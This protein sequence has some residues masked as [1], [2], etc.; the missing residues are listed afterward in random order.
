MPGGLTRP[1]TPRESPARRATDGSVPASGGLL[2]AL[3]HAVLGP[4]PQM[5]VHMWQC[6]IAFGL[7]CVVAIVQH[8]EVLLG[9][10]EAPQSHLLTAYT[11]GTSLLCCGLVRSG[12]ARRMA[13]GDPALTMVQALLAVTALGWS[14]AITGPARGAL[15]ALLAPLFLLGGMF[16]LRA[17]QTRVLMGYWLALVTA[18]MLWR[19]SGDAPRYDPRVEVI[20][21]AFSLIVVTA[22]A[23]LA[24]RISTLLTRLAAQKA[25][26]IEALETSRKLAEHDAL[27]GL[28]NRRGMAGLLTLHWTVGA[29]A[30]APRGVK[31]PASGAP[32]A[33]AM[34]DIDL[35]KNVNDTHGHA[36]GDAVLQ[37]FAQ[38]AQ[39][40]VRGRDVLS[41]W[42]GE[43][44]L[45][46]MPGTGR[47][48]A[49]RVLE[50]LR[51]QIARGEFGALAP[52][53]ELTFSA[54][55]AERQ[56]GEPYDAAV[57]RADKALYRAKHN[58]RNRF[59]A[60]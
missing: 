43:E 56:A 48:G 14:Y 28:L 58:G 22:V 18:V 32:M 9:L 27:T 44:F 47:D 53:L 16:Q 12:L 25:S 40:G 4:G 38:I 31:V 8:A 55:V 23:A 51:G 59:E 60:G 5:Q 30:Q 35:F 13:P 6:L 49:M 46:L 34:M 50:R 37:R 54:G 26:L 1:T 15:L 24:I 10:I 33:I 2:G 42:G 52:G 39:A 29:T 7:L 11:L 21:W 57:E 41:R 3:R 17:A 36:V 45:L 19:T 20:H